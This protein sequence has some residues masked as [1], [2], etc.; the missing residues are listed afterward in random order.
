MIPKGYFCLS[1]RDVTMK[2][3]GFSKNLDSSALSELQKKLAKAHENSCRIKYV[4]EYLQ[5][6]DEFCEG[7]VG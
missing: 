6:Q 2:I 1:L 3:F 5:L 4:L 7:F